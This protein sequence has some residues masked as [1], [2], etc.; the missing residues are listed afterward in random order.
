VSPAPSW[1]SVSSSRTSSPQGNREAREQTY[2]AAQ[3]FIQENARSNGSIQ[4]SD[5]LGCDISTPAGLAQ[6]RESGMFQQR[7]PHLMREAVARFEELFPNTA[8]PASPE[9]K[10]FRANAPD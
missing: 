3:R 5:L 8:L 10:S 1:P 9:S 2:D 4:C 6:A 7:C